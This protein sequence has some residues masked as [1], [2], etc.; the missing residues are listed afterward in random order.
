MRTPSHGSVSSNA[1]YASSGNRVTLTVTPSRG[2]ELEDIT[3]T[4]KKTGDVISVSSS[5]SDKYR[6]TMPAANVTVEAFFREIAVSDP[7]AVNP[8]VT[9]AVPNTPNLPAAIVYADVRVTDWYYDGVQYMAQRGLMKGT[10]ATEFDSHSNTTRAMVWTMLA[11][12]AGQSTDGGSNWYQKG[13]D[14][15]IASGITDGSDPNGT[16]TREQLATMLWRTTG[17][18]ASSAQLSQFSDS[19]KINAYAQDALRWAT[20]HGIMNGKGGG[21]LDPQGLATRAEV[22]QMFM[23]YMVKTG[24]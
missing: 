11:R 16:I 4:N 18:P 12:M 14:W 9:P 17:S 2:Y 13:M 7:V 6:F 21:M 24:A 19:G 5:R 3:V 1:D 22:A 10:S 15:C 8:P 23:N 20:E